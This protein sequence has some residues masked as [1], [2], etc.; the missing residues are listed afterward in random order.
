MKKLVSGEK[1]AYFCDKR[2]TYEQMMAIIKD[3]KLE[4]HGSVFVFCAGESTD[5][6]TVTAEDL[7]S[8]YNLDIAGMV[9]PISALETIGDYN[10]YLN[11][12]AEFELVN[13]YV[14]FI[15]NGLI[16]FNEI[17]EQ[18]LTIAEED[19]VDY[20]YFIRQNLIRLKNLGKMETILSEMMN[21]MAQFS[22][23]E[24]FKQLLNRF[25]CDND[26]YEKIALDTAPY[27]VFRG[28]ETCF[29]VLE[30]FALSLTKELKR[31]GKP[32]L[33]LEN[34]KMNYDYLQ[35]HMFKAIIG[36][37]SNAF[38]V[39]YFQKLSGKKIN[40]WTDNPI[41][42]K[43]H[44]EKYPKDC[45]IL[46]QDVN[47]AKYIK[48]EF[49]LVNAMHMPLGG[50]VQEDVMNEERP[51]DIIFIAK[52]FMINRDGWNDNEKN[53]YDYM[54][55]NPQLTFYEGIQAWMKEK[56]IS[57]K[58][59]E[60]SDILTDLK[61]ICQQVINFY[62]KKIIDTI[63]EAGIQLHVYG[64]TWAEYHSPWE[65][66]L[67]RHPEV[68]VAESLREWQKAKIGLNIMSWHKAGMTERVANIMMAGAVCL[69]DETSY[70][71]E[72]FSDGEEIVLFS[73]EKIDEVPRMIS[74]LLKE[75]RW[76]KIAQAGKKSA[77]LNYSWEKK[78]QE[79][80]KLVELQKNN[81]K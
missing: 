31:L 58:K 40:Y 29:G 74:N 77:E 17:E 37:Q 20:V 46:C 38:C 67:V 12:L 1:N 28:D 11:G 53:F 57:Y 51:Y 42:Y 80:V 64:H 26:L 15:G 71:R 34:G 72:Y 78:A 30:D 63:L 10:Q 55:A 70:L 61:P 32:V 24:S 69:S 81:K 49:G 7:L 62:R 23:A 35:N 47:Y 60:I 6:V 2:I 41:F 79:L 9:A 36:F 18:P 3:Q 5:A 52:Y 4:E 65:E 39:E 76:K 59:E 44:F 14:D 25:L 22:F 75:S 16:V 8:C 56:G 33:L 45:Y 43:Y 73:L 66:N 50:H 19:V 13:R 68:S 54:C 21:L 48:N 27:V